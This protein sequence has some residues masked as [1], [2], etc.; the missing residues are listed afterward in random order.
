[1]THYVFGYGSLA[2]LGAGARPAELVG[3]RRAWTVAMDNTV[4]LPGYKHYLDVERARPA[5]C[6]AFLDLVEHDAAVNGVCL[7]VTDTDLAVLDRRERQYVRV[8]VSDRMTHTDGPSWAYLGRAESRE[9]AA[10]ARAD[11]RLRVA[12]AYLDAVHVAFDALGPE[13]R[14]RFDATTHAPG[15][16]VVDLRRVDTR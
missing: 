12:R 5:V 13:Q 9:R 16:P 11:G 1:M 6:V 10:A 8:D 4:D 7:P 14:A 15:V 3:F 2:S